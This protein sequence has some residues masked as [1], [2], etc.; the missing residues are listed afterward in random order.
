MPKQIRALTRRRQILVPLVA[1]ALVPLSACV[2]LAEIRDFAALSK[3]ASESF[4]A[5]MADE[6]DSF[7]RQRQMEYLQQ[8]LSLEDAIKQAHADCDG[9]DLCK[10]VPDWIGASKVL[11]NYMNVM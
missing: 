10:N 3:K 8:H 1:A 7:I 5:L 2:T 11:E 9:H 6:K 4:P